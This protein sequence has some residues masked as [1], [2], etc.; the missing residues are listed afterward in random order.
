[1]DT[2]RLT[3][4][5]ATT[6]LDA[7]FTLPSAAQD[8]SELKAQIEALTKKVEELQKA[9][10]KTAIVKK[11]EPAPALATRDGKYEMNMR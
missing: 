2:K 11:S 6:A 8:L 7:M 9:T 10:D 1:M 3:T 4:L 5:M